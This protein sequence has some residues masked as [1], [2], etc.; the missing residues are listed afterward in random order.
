M[1]GRRLLLVESGGID[2]H[3]PSPVLGDARQHVGGA[4]RASGSSRAGSGSAIGP[5][6][7]RPGRSAGGASTWRVTSGGGAGLAAA[8]AGEGARRVA[9]G[10]VTVGAAAPAVAARPRRRPSAAALPAKTAP[11]PRQP[12]STQR[13]RWMVGGGG[14]RRGHAPAPPRSVLSLASAPSLRPWLSA[15][16]QITP[17]FDVT[18]F[19]AAIALASTIASCNW[20]SVVSGLAGSNFGKSAGG[21]SGISLAIGGRSVRG[22]ASRLAGAALVLDRA[23]QIRLALRPEMR[24]LLARL[25]HVS[26]PARC[27]SPWIDRP[28]GV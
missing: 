3:R 7:S 17:Q 26:R 23:V 8:T 4:R 10:R 6:V 15:P 16:A 1:R 18:V 27:P 14:G 20:K 11:R 24:R 5:G 28:D 19:C 25:R 9:A 13:L 22:G 12:A 21:L 2:L